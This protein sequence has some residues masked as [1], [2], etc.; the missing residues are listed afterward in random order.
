VHCSVSKDQILL[1]FK[2]SPSLNGSVVPTSLMPC[3]YC[4]IKKYDGG[5]DDVHC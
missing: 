4:W 5:W 3:W 2:L 1:D